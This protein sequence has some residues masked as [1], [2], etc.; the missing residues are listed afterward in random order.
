MLSSR[1]SKRGRPATL[2]LHSFKNLLKVYLGA[3]SSP[4][5][6][7]TCPLHPRFSYWDVTLSISGLRTESGASVI[8]SGRMERMVSK[9]CVQPLFHT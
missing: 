5:V 4:P 1:K 7:L 2:Y 6:S 3:S 9:T 8:L